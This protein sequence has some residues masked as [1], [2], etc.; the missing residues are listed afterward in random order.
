MART[1]SRL[2]RYA[3]P[4]PLK[5]AARF[6][7]V[8]RPDLIALVHPTICS[9]HG[10]SGRPVHF[11]SF[12]VCARAGAVIE[13]SSNTFADSISAPASAVHAILLKD[14]PSERLPGSIE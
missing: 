13:A 14:H 5:A 2:A 4:R 8:Y 6:L 1:R 7:P 9:S 3:V 10:M 12:S 11:E